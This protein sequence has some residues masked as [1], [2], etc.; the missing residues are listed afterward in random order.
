[1]PCTVKSVLYV[2]GPT[3]WLPVS[4]ELGPD[5]AGERAPTRKK[6]NAVTQYMMPSFLWSV[7]VI[8]ATGPL[9]CTSAGRATRGG[10]A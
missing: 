5:R 7:V 8:H 1:M 10:C 9:R 6:V 2:C 4:R 3:S